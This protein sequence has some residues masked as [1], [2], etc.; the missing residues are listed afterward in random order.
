MTAALQPPIARDDVVY[1][2][3]VAFE[4][5][6]IDGKAWR[7]FT[8]HIEGIPESP[9]PGCSAACQGTWPTEPGQ[10]QKPFHTRSCPNRPDRTPTVQRGYGKG[11]SLVQGECPACGARSLFLGSGGYVTC[12]GPTCG[13]PSAASHTLDPYWDEPSKENP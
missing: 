1:M 6:V 11:W 12:A 7:W 13:N 8:D 2:V 9:L 3:K 10:P 4:N 5:N